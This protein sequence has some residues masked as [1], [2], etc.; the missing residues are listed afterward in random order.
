MVERE[1]WRL[2]FG[3]ETAWAWVV[4]ALAL[5]LTLSVWRL[6][7]DQVHSA[8]ERRFEA[9]RTE[10]VEAIRQRLAAYEQV[11]RGG[12]GLFATFGAVSRDEWARW[13][14]ALRVEQ[15]YPGVQG[16][17]YA[18]WLAPHERAAFVAQVRKE[19]FSEFAITPPGE[20]PNYTSIVYLEPF[21]RRNR[22]AFGYDMWSEPVRR[23]AMDAARDTGETVVSG[24]VTLVQEIDTDVQ[25]GFLMYRAHYAAPQR[26]TTPAARR[27]ALEGFVYAPFRMR[28]FM[29][30]L[31]PWGLTDLRIELFDGNVLTASN[32]LHDSRPDAPASDYVRAFPFQVNGRVWTMR[33]SALPELVTEVEAGRPKAILGGGVAISLLLFGATLASLRTQ[34]A[35]AEAADL[36]RVV[37]DAASEVLVLD[38]KSLRMLRANRGARDNLGYDMEE[39][40]KLRIVELEADAGPF[41]AALRRT[42]GAQS[43]SYETRRV[44]KNGERYHVEVTLQRGRSG[45]RAVVTAIGRDVSE[46]KR[47]EAQ[48]RMLMSELDHRVKNTLATVQ[49]L[50]SHSAGSGSPAK[51]IE[52]FSGRLAALAR[53]HDLLTQSSWQGADLAELARQQLGPYRAEDRRNLA[54]EGPSVTLT[55]AS[56]LALGIALHELATNAAKH[57]ALATAK[58]RV[59]L[60][61]RIDA[62]EPDRPVIELVWR[63]RGGPPPP[64][65]PPRGFG[66]TLIERGLAYEL[67]AEVRFSFP[68]EGLE[69][70]IRA[71]LAS[72]AESEPQPGASPP[73]GP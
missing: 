22:A 4:L 28:D 56:A 63:E 29:T 51:F 30:G 53:S 34:L 31:L 39:L 7:A 48:Q 14:A 61:W 15:N 24:R 50:A 16:V 32:L 27:R 9:R 8:V 2:L 68:P 60:S 66:R 5:A 67:D 62:R 71:P 19:G 21:D 11:L 72:V 70:A 33:A 18:K 1:R 20:R 44:R 64:P 17:G 13:L 12:V 6:T 41:L 38:A 46:R 40:R 73:L 52:S 37:E 35:R 23:A 26:P 36:G 10:L 49:S 69:C 47:A 42:D 58:G 59:A 43:A 55:P 57:G 25:P 45:G 65:E 3:R 54:A